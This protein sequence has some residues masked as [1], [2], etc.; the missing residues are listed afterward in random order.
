M[1]TLSKVTHAQATRNTPEATARR[2]AKSGIPVFPC[3]PATKAPYEKG[4]FH[5]A[6][7]D[8]A[9]IRLWW[10]RWPDA[11]VAIP[12]GSA[13]ERV[14]LDLDNKTGEHEGRRSLEALEAEHGELPDTVE[15]ITPSGG[16][17]IVFKAPPGVRVPCSAGKLGTGV[18][19]R[20]D[21][22]YALVPGSKG[23]QWEAAHHPND[24]PLADIPAWL[25]RA[26]LASGR[27]G[28]PSR[29]PEPDALETI[30]EGRRN[31]TMTSHAGRLRSLG[32]VEAEIVG[33]LAVLNES[34]CDPPLDTD[35]LGRIAHSASR[36]DQ[37]DFAMGPDITDVQERAQRSATLQS[38]TIRAMAHPRARKLVTVA[39][40]LAAEITR[41]KEQGVHPDTT[42][43]MYYISR[44]VLG[45]HDFGTDSWQIKETTVRNHTEELREY[46]PHIPGF[47]ARKSLINFPK[48][49]VDADGVIVTNPETG[50]PE[51]VDRY[52][53]TWCY[54]FDGDP[55]QIVAALPTLPYPEDR[56]GK[57]CATCGAEKKTKTVEYCAACEIVQVIPAPDRQGANFAPTPQAADLGTGGHALAP[58]GSNQ[59][60]VTRGAKFAPPP[61]TGVSVG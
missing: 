49:R 14:I 53:L 35:E 15:A 1:T 2:Y 59:H 26:M 37:G 60:G 9:I 17:H 45:G 24:I 61:R 32:Y 47:A 20:G 8:L 13:S 33:M 34:R 54:N 6:T 28:A 50:E 48:K 7:T 23:Y 27:T 40:R 51:M 31:S 46:A 4:G 58:I 41:R 29:T 43:G 3:I 5:K 44:D 21:A 10:Q 18:D 42:D 11:D 52:E 55:A 36:W 39:T 12:T 38:A 16:A 30:P 56:R 19:V 57:R 22:G 25:L